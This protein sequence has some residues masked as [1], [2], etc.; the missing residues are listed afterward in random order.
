MRLISITTEGDHKGPYPAS[1][2]APA[3]TM[4]TDSLTRGFVIIVRAGV[5]EALGGALVV[6]LGWRLEREF[7]CRSQ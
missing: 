7:L 6:A 3:L 5:V 2:S 4:T 1:T